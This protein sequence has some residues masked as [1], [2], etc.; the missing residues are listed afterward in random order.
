MV[1]GLVLLSIFAAVVGGAAAWIVAGFWWG[2]A[3]YIG[4]GAATV[5]LVG[6]IRALAPHA[7]GAR[8]QNLLNKATG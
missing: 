7:E 8:A 5:L 6:A 2:V 4:V 3:A 1:A